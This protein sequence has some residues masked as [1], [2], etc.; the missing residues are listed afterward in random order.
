LKKLGTLL[1]I[2]GMIG[3][4]A[5]SRQLIQSFSLELPT[6]AFS[7]PTSISLGYLCA[8]IAGIAVLQKNIV[9]Q[10][11]VV[12]KIWIGLF[13]LQLLSLTPCFLAKEALCGVF[14][15]LLASITT[16]FAVPAL[17]IVL[18]RQYNTKFAALIFASIASLVMGLFFWLAPRSVKDCKKIPQELERGECFGHLAEKFK[19]EKLCLEMTFGP[20]RATCLRTL[21]EAKTDVNI[22]DLIQ[23]SEKME[24]P[25]INFKPDEYRDVCYWVLAFQR[26]DVTIC[27][28]ITNNEQRINCSQKAK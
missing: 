18:A 24:S 16:V 19:D 15:I 12:I 5:W 3:V 14:Y 10:S 2:G 7:L 8:V 22:C 25:G 20:S 23:A 26:H 11:T 27:A 9:S 6:S 4:A 1:L 17:F 28:K 21:A 13:V